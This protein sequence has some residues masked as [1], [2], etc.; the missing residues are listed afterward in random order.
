M[1]VTWGGGLWDLGKQP[2]AAP[3]VSETP[4]QGEQSAARGRR[5]AGTWAAGRSIRLPK[6]RRLWARLSESPSRLWDGSQL[7]GGCS[8]WPEH[9]PRSRDVISMKPRVSKW[10]DAS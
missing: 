10:G 5:G 2:P 3:P 4:T 9:G 1:G 8:T 7:P 6:D